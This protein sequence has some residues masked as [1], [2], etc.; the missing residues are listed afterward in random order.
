M[1]SEPN[2]DTPHRNTTPQLYSHTETDWWL[3]SVEKYIDC[4][5]LSSSCGHQIN[6]QINN[7]HRLNLVTMN[8]KLRILRSSLFNY[9]INVLEF[10]SLETST[11]SSVK[12]SEHMS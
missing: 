4:G 2:A 6:L 10:T 5:I 11:Q 12:F 8:F 7:L 1:H 9:A 3:P